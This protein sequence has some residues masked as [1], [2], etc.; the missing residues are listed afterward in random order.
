MHPRYQ[1]YR[2]RFP[3]SKVTL[4]KKNVYIL[5]LLLKGVQ[6]IINTFLIDD[7]SILPF[8][9]P[10]YLE[11]R[12]SPWIFEKIQNGLIGY[13]GALGETDSWKKPEDENLMALSL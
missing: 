9:F 2:Q 12:I 6:I 3:V 13:P 1:Q 5:T 4:K 10:F 7:F 11:L 8:H